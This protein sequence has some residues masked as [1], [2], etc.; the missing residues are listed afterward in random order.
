[1][2]LQVKIDDSIYQISEWFLVNGLT[3]NP[4]KTNIIKVKKNTFTL[5][6]LTL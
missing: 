1:M 3:L 6:I 2:E 4:D 5:G